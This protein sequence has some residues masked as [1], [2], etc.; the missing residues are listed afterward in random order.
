MH[1]TLCVTT[2]TGLAHHWLLHAENSLA[3][4]VTLFAALLALVSGMV[5]ISY[6]KHQY[7][8]WLSAA[9]LLAAVATS[10]RKA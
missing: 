10:C 7:L 8:L 9:L 1:L 4:T 6:R 3:L 5:W 2:L